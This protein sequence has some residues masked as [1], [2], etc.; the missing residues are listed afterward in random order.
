MELNQI[1]HFY[2]GK[3][4]FITGHTGFKGSWMLYMLD[5]VGAIVTGFSLAPKTTP[6]LH[7]SLKFSNNITSIYGD[8]RNKESFK[9]AFEK[10]N[11]EFIFHMAAQPLVIKS[12]QNPEETFDINFKGTLNLLEIVKEF[13]KNVQAVFVTTDKVYENLEIGLPFVETD[14]LGGKDPY[15]ASKA[16]SE[17]LINSYN[18]SFF[19]DS[20]I[21][22][23]TAR[24]GNVIGGGDWSSNRLIP[25]IIK[26]KQNNTP[27]VIRNPKAI[28]PWQHVLEP[29]FGYLRLG[30]GLFKNPKKNMGCWN[31]GPHNEDLKS[32]ED[33]IDIGKKLN[34][35]GEVH[36]KPSPFTE[37]N[38][39]KLNIDKAQLKL[40]FKPVWTSEIAVKRTF[41][42]Y[43]KFYQKNI[44][45]NKLIESDLKKYLNYN[46]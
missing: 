34:A 36:Y 16:A 42:W 17:I 38:I 23:A 45:I 25:D 35:I 27:L 13:N 26:S 19:K 5:S 4:V 43:K 40:D 9:K 21:S 3:R 30:I 12:Y 20:N 31:F 44:S 18:Q 46:Q 10:S 7:K 11:P 39:L 24:A 6:S 8:I 1:L 32:V 14:S 2:K 37:A 41:E 28:R 29:L 33:L 22:I 15:S